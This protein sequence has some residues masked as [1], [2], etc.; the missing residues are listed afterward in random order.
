[1]RILLD[2]CVDWRLSRSLPAHEVKSA[3]EMGWEQLRNGDLLTAASAQFDVLLTVDQKMK[4]QQNL[5]TH[6]R[7]RADGEVEPTC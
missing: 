4:S 5:S 3:Q 1:M 6:S 2:H 7:H